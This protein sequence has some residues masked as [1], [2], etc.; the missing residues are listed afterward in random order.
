MSSSV[1]TTMVAPPPA[2]WSMYALIGVPSGRTMLTGWPRAFCPS[3]SCA[4]SRKVERLRHGQACAVMVTVTVAVLPPAVTV[5]WAVPAFLRVMVTTVPLDGRC[6]QRL[7][8]GCDLDD[9][10]G[11]V[12]RG[13]GHVHG[14]G[15]ALFTVG[16]G[17]GEGDGFHGHASG[18][19]RH[20]FD[21]G[22]AADQ[23]ARVGG[24]GHVV[25]DGVA[26]GILDVAVVADGGVGQHDA[27]D[28]V[29]GQEDFEHDHAAFAGRHGVAD[30]D[31]VLV[32]RFDVGG[33]VAQLGAGLVELQRWRTGRFRRSW[34]FPRGP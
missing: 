6:R 13:D 32:G 34:R 18:D 8:V 9:P 15:G 24:E 21:A 2:C 33:A 19:D 28:L 5:M 22:R 23:L 27:L 1:A 30:G 14:V 25:G 29:A 3:S 11:G 20:V 12:D 17:L 7:V 31:G 26:G 4:T 16:F 10:I